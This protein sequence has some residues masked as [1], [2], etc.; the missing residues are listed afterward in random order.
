MDT[1][2]SKRHGM[3]CTDQS[4]GRFADS[5]PLHWEPRLVHEET[6]A[7][8]HGSS[9]DES[10][11]EGREVQVKWIRFE[12]LTVVIITRMQGKIIT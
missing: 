12:F 1:L 4:R 7:G 3:D 9:A 6:Q 2:I 10:T 8:L 11:S 5:G